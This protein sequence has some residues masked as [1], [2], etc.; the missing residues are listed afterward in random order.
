MVR[1]LAIETSA[2]VGSVATVEDGRVLV[3]EQFPHGLQHAA[4][5]VP[6]INRLAKAQAWE[7]GDLGELLSSACKNDVLSAI[8]KPRENGHQLD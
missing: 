7:P 1:G 4:Q 6:I 2:R 3:E 8:T 5:I